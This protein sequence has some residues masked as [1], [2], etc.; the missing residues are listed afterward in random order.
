MS[1][2]QTCFVLLLFELLQELA[3]QLLVKANNSQQI[4]GKSSSNSS[5]SCSDTVSS[6]PSTI[7]SNCIKIRLCKNTQHHHVTLTPACQSYPALT[8]CLHRRGSVFVNENAKR[9]TDRRRIKEA[10]FFFKLHELF[11]ILTL[12]LP[13]LPTDIRSSSSESCV[14]G[15]ESEMDG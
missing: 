7:S 15:R 1:G 14:R 13:R 8:L 11:V 9:I 6:Y 10:L 5:I 12:A 3:N 2:T 4:S